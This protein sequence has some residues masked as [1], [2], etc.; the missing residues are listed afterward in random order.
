VVFVIAAPWWLATQRQ[1]RPFQRTKTG[2]RGAG[3]LLRVNHEQLNQAYV[4]TLSC[5]DRPGI[6]HAVAGA[7]LVAG[8]NIMDSQQ[9]GSPS[10]GN[11]FMRVEVTTAAPK[12]E[13]RAALEPVA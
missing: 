10:T 4:V 8:C 5:P 2:T 3:R 13:L 7:L 6:V 11:F 9:Y 1:L 12:S